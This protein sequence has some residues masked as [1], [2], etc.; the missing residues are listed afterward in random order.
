[1]RRP[2][3]ILCLAL[4]LLSLV[5][6]V[7]ASQTDLIPDE[8]Y[9]WSWSLH[10]DWCYWDQPAGIAWATFFWTKVFGHSVV[11]LRG[12]AVLCS[13]LASLFVFLLLRKVLD[14]FSAL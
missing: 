11:T 3:V 5:R 13:A 12:L 2:F 9:Y 1:V 10:P 14:E 8:A 7:I 4:L 6:L